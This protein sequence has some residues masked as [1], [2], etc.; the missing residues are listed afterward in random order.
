MDYNDW[1]EEL[2]QEDKAHSKWR[3]KAR[4]VERRYRL[5]QEEHTSYNILWANVEI[6]QA[7]LYSQTPKPDVQRRFKDGNPIGKDVAILL[8]RALSFSIDS[9]DFDGILQ[10]AVNNYLVS[11]LGQVRVNYVPFFGEGEPQRIDLE[12]QVDPETQTETALRDGEPVEEFER[13]EIGPFVME[14]TE[15]I[16]YQAV[17]CS[18]VPWS[19]FRYSPRS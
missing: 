13:D 4:K 19:R 7:A 8:E 3:E 12:V 16:D 2:A 14:T 11:A 6:L 1:L 5:E 17:D 15:Q 18:T 9:Y 10:P